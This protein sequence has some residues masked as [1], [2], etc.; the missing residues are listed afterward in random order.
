MVEASDAQPVCLALSASEPSRAYIV[1]ALWRARIYC[2]TSHMTSQ[3]EH[4][5]KGPSLVSVRHL[6]HIKSIAPSG[7]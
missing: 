6:L 2:N 7:K 3:M 5:S 4:R 1:Q